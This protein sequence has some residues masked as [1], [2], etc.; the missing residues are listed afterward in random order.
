MCEGSDE[1]VGR[2]VGMC[3]CEESV[4]GWVGSCV[5]RVW[6]GGWGRV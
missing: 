1:S 6:V 2:V 5:R 4:G 3:V